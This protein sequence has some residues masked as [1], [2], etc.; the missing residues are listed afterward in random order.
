MKID[1]F[2]HILPPHF[3]QKMLELEPTIP[4]KFP[5]IR[6][7]KVLLILMKD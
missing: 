2:A 7:L 3:Y 6:I 4:Q 1:A 5:F